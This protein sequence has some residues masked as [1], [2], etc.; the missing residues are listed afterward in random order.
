MINNDNFGHTK[1][2]DNMVGYEKH[3]CGSIFG[4]IRHNLDQL[5]E[6]LNNDN[7]IVV[8]ISQINTYMS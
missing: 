5:V 1:V 3:N 7:D 4:R 8:T 6:V 2:S